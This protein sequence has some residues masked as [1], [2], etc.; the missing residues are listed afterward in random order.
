MADLSKFRG[1]FLTK[2]NDNKAHW[3]I[4]EHDDATFAM[5]MKI[6]NDTTGT[7][8]ITG[9]EL[10]NINNRRCLIKNNI[11]TCHNELSDLIMEIND[12]NLTIT[13]CSFAGNTT[14]SVFDRVDD[15][16]CSDM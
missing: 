1:C 14:R 2:Q 9:R 8:I 4:D 16:E 11:L 5:R 12:H 7:K 6:S 15:S 13:Q 3:R 10:F